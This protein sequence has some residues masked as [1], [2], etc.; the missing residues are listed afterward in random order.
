[1]SIFSSPK[2]KYIFFA[3]IILAAILRFYNLSDPDMFDDEVYYALRGIGYLD[4]LGSTLQSTPIYWFDPFPGWARLSMHDH[5][6]LT[7]LVNKI[8]FSIFGVSVFVARLPSVL[9]GLASVLL[10]YLIGKKMFG[11][12]AGLAAAAIFAI[13]DF[14]V[15]VNRTGLMESVVIMLILLAWYLF[16]LALENKNYLYFWGAALGVSWLAKYTAFPLLPICLIYLAVS[17]RRHFKDY[18]LYLSILVA[19]LIFSPV[20]IYNLMLF[21]ETGHFDLQFAALFN[22]NVPEWQTLTQKE[23]GTLFQNFIEI[24]SGLPSVFSP[25]TLALAVA[26]IIYSV[27]QA[28]KI[29]SDKYEPQQISEQYVKH[30]EQARDKKQSHLLLLLF[31][32]F[33]TLLL[34]VIKPLQ[35]FLTYYLLFF[36]LFISAFFAFCLRR[37]KPADKKIIAVLAAVFL[38]YELAFSINTNLL[39]LSVGPANLAWSLVRPYTADFGINK[40]D[41]YLNAE[42]QNKYSA[43]VP[44]TGNNF[45]DEMISK[46]FE[47]YKVGKTPEPILLVYNTHLHEAATLWNFDRR[48]LYQGWPAIFVDDFYRLL[49]EQGVK[50]FTG[51]NIYYITGT[52]YSLWRDA[53]LFT[54]AAIDLEAQLKS[55]G[56]APDLINNHVN[57]PV[58]KI[59]KFSL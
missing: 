34:I 36:P 24:F 38:I 43:G 31:L 42:L 19:I 9:A 50:Q 56:N 25:A 15:W 49:D 30:S 17:N 21:K 41:K 33:Y 51:Y 10:L 29:L 27:Y 1:M 28:V 18:R 7:F 8:F 53:G 32:I 13:G 20:I 39:P 35:R 23:S 4:Y 22:Q 11:P 37:S 12:R 59:Y 54:S 46:N 45:L 55:Q 3:I 52:E 44:K 48:F 2:I 14:S 57:L 26:G 47:K 40:L 16:L 5:P 58:F 6:P